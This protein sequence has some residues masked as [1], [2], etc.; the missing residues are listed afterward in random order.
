MKT[1]IKTLATI[2]ILGFI[3]TIN[4]N[5]ANNRNANNNV[6]VEE[7]KNLKSGSNMS[8]EVLP[9]L[10]EK[11]NFSESDANFESV[12]LILSDDLDA[13]VDLQKEAQ[14]V[15]KW[16]AD[17]EEAK[18][19]Q[20]LITGGKFGKVESTQFFLNENLDAKIDLQREAGS[21][22]KWIVDQEEA[23]LTQKL[24]DEGKLEKIN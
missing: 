10:I 24:I 1:N 23:K 20:K 17:R 16:I 21:V 3:A 13:K 14:L 12:Q 5:A 22:T 7:V 8:D 2:C 9:S 19:N 4:V 11:F 18:L 6:V 15:T